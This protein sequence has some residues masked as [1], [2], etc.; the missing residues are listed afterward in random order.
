MVYICILLIY[1]NCVHVDLAIALF[2]LERGAKKASETKKKKYS[3]ECALTV[4]SVRKSFGGCVKRSGEC[5]KSESG[6]LNQSELLVSVWLVTFNESHRANDR[7]ASERGL[8]RWTRR[9]QNSSAIDTPL[10]I[11]LFANNAFV[12]HRGQ[13]TNSHTENSKQRT[14][15]QHLR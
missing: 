8:E 15:G 1:E 2:A 4:L 12:A 10:R 3:T 13:R 9:E 14:F 11:E 6:W 5:L 7:R